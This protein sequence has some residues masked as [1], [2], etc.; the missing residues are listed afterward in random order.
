VCVRVVQGCGILDVFFQVV[1][2]AKVRR[3]DGRPRHPPRFY[4]IFLIYGDTPTRN[5]D[6]G[7]NFRAN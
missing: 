4:L 7:F 6:V 2:D 1:A 3:G 5:L